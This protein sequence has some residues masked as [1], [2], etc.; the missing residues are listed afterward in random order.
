MR[1]LPSAFVYYQSLS[2][3]NIHS[4][5]QRVYALL[6][7][8]PSYSVKRGHERGLGCLIHLYSTSNSKQM[9]PS[10]DDPKKNPESLPCAR[11]KC[12]K[13]TLLLLHRVGYMNALCMSPARC[14]LCC[15]AL[16]VPIAVWPNPARDDRGTKK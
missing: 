8:T 13:P 15:V 3:N 5:I 9:R 6:S 12:N 16:C 11:N 7:H 4:F 14:L 2:L 10:V 1:F